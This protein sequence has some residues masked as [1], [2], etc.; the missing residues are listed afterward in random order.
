MMIF[1]IQVLSFVQV[2]CSFDYN[3][4]LKIHSHPEA[5]SWSLCI[6]IMKEKYWERLA[7]LAAQ[8]WWVRRPDH[9]GCFSWRRESPVVECQVVWPGRVTEA[10][11]DLTNVF[12]FIALLF[13]TSPSVLPNR[14]NLPRKLYGDVIHMQNR[15][16]FSE[17]MCMHASVSKSVCLCV[18]VHVLLEWL[19]PL[20]EGPLHLPVN[21]QKTWEK[22]A[23]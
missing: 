20:L 19:I 2:A 3:T 14:Q 23:D 10:G 5:I 7:K 4:K 18:C 22:L 8:A 12:P 9:W 21:S 15:R 6:Y 17:W 11:S 16:A 1:Q 13:T